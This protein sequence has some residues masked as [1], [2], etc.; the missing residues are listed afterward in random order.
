MTLLALPTSTAK[1]LVTF[2]DPTPAGPND[3]NTKHAPLI[4]RSCW[5]AQ[6]PSAGVTEI[7]TG[8][9]TPRSITQFAVLVKAPKTLLSPAVNVVVNVRFANP[10]Q[11]ANGNAVQL[12]PVPPGVLKV[13]RTRLMLF[14]TT[15]VSGTTVS[16]KPSPFESQPKAKALVTVLPARC[17][18]TPVS[19]EKP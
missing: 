2:V 18:G 6:L 15:L 1:T 8:A 10:P 17:N 11:H 7:T 13:P 3:G 4:N 14:G 9:L 19:L 12:S 5:T 16:T